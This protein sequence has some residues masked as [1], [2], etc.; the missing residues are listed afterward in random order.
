MKNR[1]KLIG[2]IAFVAVIGLLLASCGDKEGTLVIK[3]SVGSE[4]TAYAVTGKTAPT[5]PPSGTTIKVGDSG[6]FTLEV[7][8]AYYSWSGGGKADHGTATI[9]KGEDTN[10]EAK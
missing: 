8:D 4:I 2:I 6:K 9:K 5:T 1:I 7:G 3:N 10:I